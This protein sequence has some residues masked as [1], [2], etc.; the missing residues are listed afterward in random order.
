MYTHTA[1]TNRKR[2]SKF[3]VEIRHLK[4]YYLTFRILQ[5]VRFA[6]NITKKGVS[7]NFMVTGFYKWDSL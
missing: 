2:E 3:Y 7:V 4:C 5:E 1:H 6:S